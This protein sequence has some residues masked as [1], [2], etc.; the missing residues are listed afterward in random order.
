[1][2]HAV[3]AKI[4]FSLGKEVKNVPSVLLS[5]QDK[6]ILVVHTTRR[7]FPNRRMHSLRTGRNR[8][9]HGETVVRYT[10]SSAAL[11]PARHRYGSSRV[12]EGCT[13]RV[14]RC[15]LQCTKGISLMRLKFFFQ[16]LYWSSALARMEVLIYAF[17]LV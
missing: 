17:N 13:A 7:V 12:C 3:K 2:H 6:C 1:M 9:T 10:C 5:C 16:Q 8:K 14:T 15:T 11:L 4:Q